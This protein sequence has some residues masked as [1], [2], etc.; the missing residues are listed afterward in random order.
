MKEGS[1]FERYTED[2]R[3]TIFFARAEAGKFGAECIEPP[4]FLLGL[5]I[6]D[7]P[8]VAS[9]MA[10]PV[11]VEILKN[12]IESTLP[13]AERIALSV[14]IPLS[15]SSE[16]VLDFANDAAARLKH[17]HVGGVHILLGLLKHSDTPV[18]R[19][20]DSYGIIE[21]QIERMLAE[22]KDE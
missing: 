11:A 21:S 2:A 5:L 3:R 15:K 12:E 9:T 8:L 19:A 10:N 4:H 1:M 13:R 14:E 6:A 22:F 16:D 17:K 18:A 20:L 7:R